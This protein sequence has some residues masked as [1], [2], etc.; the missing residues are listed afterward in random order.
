MFFHLMIQRLTLQLPIIIIL[1]GSPHNKVYTEHRSSSYGIVDIHIVLL[2]EFASFFAGVQN[3]LIPLL[4]VAGEL[5]F[6][7]QCS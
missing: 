3:V 2:V 4:L 5:G 6:E 1:L 7:L